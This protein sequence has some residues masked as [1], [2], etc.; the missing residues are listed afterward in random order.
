M[1]QTSRFREPTA[2]DEY[3]PC[4]DCGKLWHFTAYEN[5]D[6]PGPCCADE[7]EKELKENACKQA[8]AC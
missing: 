2:S 1:K 7:P 5:D 6:G 3:Y 8:D 4:P